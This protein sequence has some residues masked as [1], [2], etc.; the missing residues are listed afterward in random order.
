M[1]RLRSYYSKG[2][3]EAGVDEVGR[4]CLAGPVVAAA[5]ILPANFRHRLLNDSKMM[6]AKS[7][8]ILSAYIQK[9]AISYA[10]AEVDNEEIDKINIL[11]A[12]FKAMHIA[13]DELESRPEHILVDGNRFN[14]YPF[15][16]HTCVVKGDSKFK[17]IAAASVLAKVYRD[18]L[19]ANLHQDRPYYGWE[20]NAGYPTKEHRKGIREHGPSPLHRM[21]FRLLEEES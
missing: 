12:S 19:M 11:Q 15:I 21:S 4:G 5:V 3:I 6:S 2:L 9:K 17:C 8:D 7:R 16:P 10:I 1:A 14:P 18:R 13:L 20:R